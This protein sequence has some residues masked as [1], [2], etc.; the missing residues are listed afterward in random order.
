MGVAVSLEQIRNYRLAYLYISAYGE[1]EEIEILRK[2]GHCKCGQLAVKWNSRE[3]ICGNC[4]LQEVI[5]R[6]DFG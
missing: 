6:I 1:P 2:V 4:S 3:P 5:G